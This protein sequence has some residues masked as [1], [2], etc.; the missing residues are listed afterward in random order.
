[1][2]PREH[3]HGNKTVGGLSRNRD[4]NY[5]LSSQTFGAIADAIAAVVL[6]LLALETTHS[7]VQ[8]GLVTA[9]TAT[10]SF[11]GTAVASL[12]VDRVDRRRLILL[13]LWLQTLTWGLIPLVWW[14]RG[15][16]LWPIYAV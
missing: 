3:P 2:F 12:F 7:L 9:T 5:L 6:P 16:M 14:W 10:G 13:C 15:P 11:I 1:M 8:M 4:F